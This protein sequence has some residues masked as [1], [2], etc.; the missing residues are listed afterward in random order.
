[1]IKQS[2]EYVKRTVC[3]QILDGSYSIANVAKI[4]QYP[5]FFYVLEGAFASYSSYLFVLVDFNKFFEPI[6]H[7]CPLFYFSNDFFL[8]FKKMVVPLSKT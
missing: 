1:M 2:P 6:A 5:L 7:F 8:H 3:E 4:K